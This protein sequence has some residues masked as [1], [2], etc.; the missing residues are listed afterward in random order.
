[1]IVYPVPN[2]LTLV[3][4][5][6]VGWT[7]LTPGNIVC[8]ALDDPLDPNT[9]TAPIDVVVTVEPSAY[10][11]VRNVASVSTT[12]TGD[13]RDDNEA[14]DT[15]DVGP[16]SESDWRCCVLGK[17]TPGPPVTLTVSQPPAQS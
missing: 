2:S 15:L 17:V 3:S 16:V 13:N 7:C 6:G 10:P 8:C 9:T 12:T 14:N 1:M 4:A 5:S 11:S